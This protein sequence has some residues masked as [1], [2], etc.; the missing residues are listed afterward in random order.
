MSSR[1]T[2]Y[3]LGYFQKGDT[4]RDD[5]ELQRFE[6]LDAQLYALFNVLGNGTIS[7]WNL[8]VS[9]GLAV[10]ITPGSGHVAFVAVKSAQN[11]TINN[12]TPNATNYIYAQ[13]EPDSYWNQTVTFGAY[14]SPNAE[15]VSLLLGVVTTNATAVVSIDTSGKKELGFI[16]LINSAVKNHKHIGGTDNPPPI[17]LSSEVQG[18]LNQNNLPDLDA[19][20]IQA[21]VLSNSVIPKLS[22]LTNLKDQGTFTHAQ[23]ESM[24]QSLALENNDLLGEVAIVNLLQ[25]IL[26]LKHIYPE[27]D[28]YLVNEIAIIPGITPDSYIDFTNSTAVID[29]RTAAEGGTHT[30]TGTP[31]TA[32]SLY[33]KTWNTTSVFDSGVLQGLYATNNSLSLDT[34]V[35]DLL[36]DDLLIDDFSLMEGWSV[37]TTDDSNIKSDIAL[38]TNASFTGGQSAKITLDAE[39][40]KMSFLAKKEFAP[41]DWSDYNTIRFYIYTQSVEHGDIYFYL[42]DAVSGIQNSYVKILE[43][44]VLTTNFET[45][46]NG[47]QEVEIDISGFERSA[48]NLIAISTSTQDG[49]NSAKSFSFNIDDISLTNGNVYE[50]NGYCRF[51]FGG[52]TSYNFQSVRWQGLIPPTTNVKSRARFANTELDLSLSPW[53]QYSEIS[54]N[55]FTETQLY[56]YAEIEIWMDSS[57]DNLLSPYLNAI[58]LDFYSY[59]SEN[60]YEITTQEDFEAGSL[61]NIDAKSA[62]GSIK[63][64]GTEKIGNIYYAADGLVG[65][66]DSSLSPIAGINSVIGSSLPK[67]TRQARYGKQAAMGMIT[68]M[69]YGQNGSLWIADI[70]NDRVI[71]INQ[72]GELIRGFYGSFV[73]DPTDVY[74]TEEYGPGSNIYDAETYTRDVPLT[75]SATGIEP[76]YDL[77]ILHSIYNRESNVLYVVFNKDIENIYASSSFD[78]SSI[79]I[80]IGANIVRLINATVELLGVDEAKYNAW[81]E[82]YMATANEATTHLRQFKFSSHILK[83]APSSPEA[84]YLNKLIT[85]TTPKVC[86]SNPNVNGMMP[87]SF[88]LGLVFYNFEFEANGVG[89]YAR[90]TIDN[91]LTY[92]IYANTLDLTGLSEGRHLVEV[93]LVDEFGDDYTHVGAYAK[94]DFV[95]YDKYNEPILSIVSP[96]PNQIFSTSTVNLNVKSKNYPI[97]PSGQHYQY[98]IDSGEKINVYSLNQIEIKDLSGGE[99]TLNVRLVNSNNAPVEYEYA[100]ASCKF[101][102]GLNVSATANLHWRSKFIY[103]IDKSSTIFAGKQEIDIANITMANIFAPVD[104]QVIS[105]PYLSNSLNSPSI[106]ISKLRSKTH[107]GYLSDGPKDAAT[108]VF[109]SSLYMDGHSVCQLDTQGNV[110]FSNN[111]AQFAGTREEAKNLLGSARKISSNELLIADSKN[112]RTIITKTEL[113]TQKPLIVW[114]YDSDRYIVDAQITNREDNVINVYDGHIDL[115]SILI[116]SGMQVTW[117]NLSSSPIQIYSGTTSE[118]AFAADPDLNLYGDAFQSESLAPGET[119]THQFDEYGDF[120]WFVY[121]QILTGTIHVSEQRISENDKIYMIESDGAES[122]YTSRIIKTD[123]WGNVLWSFGDGYLVKPRD[124]RI[125]TDGKLLIST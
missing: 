29:S 123:M 113:I 112:K 14:V 98:W 24:L 120:G 82:Q 89:Q 65:T 109:G 110:T 103:S 45:L 41:Q 11:V 22:H 81:V 88:T 73:N 68:G 121:P 77:E 56:K 64:A 52:T 31:F 91:S 122:P 37:G 69:D 49:W 95:V 7:G 84:S 87:P 97:L 6:T 94:C 108:S 116:S 18:V 107:G 74:G 27:I 78:I 12:L 50:D 30:I 67:T 60:S 101:I 40:I 5:I 80:R 17:D 33:T 47:W 32:K 111:A 34:K 115:S 125:M 117:K 63:V 10:T 79:Q 66:L 58:Y 35:D 96:K 46:M 76:N 53:T 9:S 102:V 61:Y 48:I 106:L 42:S 1:T 124:V 90:V 28:D 38:D 2:K 114:Q 4:T 75:T 62:P 55:A 13:L 25:L 43:R 15:N 23:I 3:Q 54:G 19:S 71:E 39:E 70:D 119:F 99:H 51:I 36:I 16:G 72:N 92:N 100:S 21:G 83:I 118:E 104:V 20:I 8:V 59:D 26:A 105:D 93:Q 86:I 57:D 44:N 85:N